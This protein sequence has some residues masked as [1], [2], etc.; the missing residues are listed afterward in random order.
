MSQTVNLHPLLNGGDRIS[1]P[2]NRMAKKSQAKR[3]C[4]CVKK[5]RKTVK[6]R[7]GSGRGAAAKEG[8]AIAICTKSILQ[9][10]GK[11]L[12]KFSCKKGPKLQTQAPLR[13]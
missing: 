12:R 4:D 9:R 1:A 11:T 10:R 3:F 7:K 8:A 2:P 5:V 13:G 6:L